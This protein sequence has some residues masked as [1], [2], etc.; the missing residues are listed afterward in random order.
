[1]AHR[2]L[3]E[4]RRAAGTRGCCRVLIYFML[5]DSSST[6]FAWQSRSVAR[7]EGSKA[8]RKSTH[9]TLHPYDGHAIGVC[10][11]CFEIADV[12]RQD[13]PAWL[14]LGDNER[15]DRRASAGAT[16]QYSR[17]ASERLRQ[18]LRHVARLE[19]SILDGVPPSMPLQALDEHRGRYARR[20]KPLCAQFQNQCQSLL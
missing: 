9:A 8:A 14:R 18:A 12:G 11:Q 6:H 2:G 13:G 4:R 5:V 15:I 17:S 19:K 20:P 3:A 7:V 1:M 16:T 10:G